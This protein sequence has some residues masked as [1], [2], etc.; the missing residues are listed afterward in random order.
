MLLW[1][2]PQLG[3]NLYVRVSEKRCSS[4]EMCAK[5]HF[6]WLGIAPIDVLR[7]VRVY[8]IHFTYPFM[9][10]NRFQL[11]ACKDDIHLFA[12]G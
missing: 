3:A 7:S 4:L 8:K 1:Q 12:N 9:R 2:H 5:L 10:W 6:I 11:F